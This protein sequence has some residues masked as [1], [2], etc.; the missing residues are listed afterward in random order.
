MME[1]EFIPYEQALQ[2]KALG[3]DESCLKYYVDTK[4]IDNSLGL[5]NSYCNWVDNQ[6]LS[7]LY[8]QAFRWFRDKHN[9][10]TWITSKTIGESD[11]VF[12][13]HGRTIPD[14]TQKGL[15]VDIIPYVTCKKEEDAELECLKK[16]I[17]IIKNK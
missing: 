15:V 12:I 6:C 14:T 1:K 7:P 9:L 4:L 5:T 10:H 8:Q 3:F 16:L 17:E 13:P 11:V 2:L